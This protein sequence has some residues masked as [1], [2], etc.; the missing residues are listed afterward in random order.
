MADL[1][2]FADFIREF[3]QTVQGRRK[4]DGRLTMS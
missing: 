2:T 4:P 3:V 1:K